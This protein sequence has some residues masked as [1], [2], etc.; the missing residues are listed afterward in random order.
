MK[1]S[2]AQEYAN[3]KLT[4]YG[5]TQL[6]WR[7]AWKPGSLSLHGQCSYRRKLIYLQ[8]KYTA[9]RAEKEVYNTILHE[10]AHALC[11]NQ[12]HNA[13]WAAKAKEVG[14]HH[15]AKRAVDIKSESEVA[16]PELMRL[17]AVK[18]SH[19]R[20]CNKEGVSRA[21]KAIRKYLRRLS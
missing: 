8:P 21:R 18:E 19:R 13:V 7:F 16:D 3:K 11:P 10:I 4:E 20:I 5:L 1:L 14:C 12:G 2:I 9:L 17:F 15:V 6:G